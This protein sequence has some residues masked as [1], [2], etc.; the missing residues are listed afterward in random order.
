MQLRAQSS[1]PATGTKLPECFCESR[2]FKISSLIGLSVTPSKVGSV[3]SSTPG[4]KRKISP[5]AETL[6]AKRV[7]ILVTLDKRPPSTSPRATFSTQPVFAPKQ[8]FPSGEAKIAHTHAHPSPA[9]WKQADKDAIWHNKHVLLPYNFQNLEVG[10]HSEEMQKLFCSIFPGTFNVTEARSRSHL[11]FQVDRLPSS[12]WPVTVGGVPITLIP[13]H[14]EHGRPLMLP[15][16]IL[17][18]PGISICSEA[19]YINA[20]EFSDNLLRQMATDVDASFIKHAPKGVRMVELMYKC[21][22][23]FYVVLEDH[24]DIPAMG[25]KLPAKIANRFVG[26]IHNKELRRPS[27][28]DLPAKREIQPQPIAGVINDNTTYDIL[29][30]G[31]L[32]RSKMLR[33]HAHP[34]VFSTKSGVL[35]QNVAGDTF[36]TAAL[37]GIGEG[38]TVWQGNR[39]DRTIG[40]AVVEISFTDVSLVKLKNDVVYINRTFETDAGTVPEFSLT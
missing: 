28:V 12:P 7:L 1:G 24:V 18:N 11:I 33:D 3:V 30:P 22:R 25:P 8:L 23:T 4:S 5:S 39:S 6:S 27:W 29:R 20:V 38:E 31:V 34:A 36:M 2:T 26:Y 9:P 10:I 17:G 15:R 16:Q 32:I 37:H 19:N 21:E 40:E 35:V 14:G 13:E